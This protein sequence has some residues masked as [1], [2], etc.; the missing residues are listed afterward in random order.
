MLSNCWLICLEP[1]CGAESDK[2]I[3]KTWFFMKT[4]EIAIFRGDG[5]PSAILPDGINLG[6]AWL[7][8]G[9]IEI[10]PRSHSIST[11]RPPPAEWRAQAIL[12][13]GIKLGGRWLALEKIGIPPRAHWDALFHSISTPGLPPAQW[14]AQAIL[15]DGINLGGDVACKEFTAAYQF[16]SL[17]TEYEFRWFECTDGTVYQSEHSILPPEILRTF[18]R[19]RKFCEEID[20]I[21]LLHA[22]VGKVRMPFYLFPD[23]PDHNNPQLAH[24]FDAAISPAAEIL[25]TFDPAHPV[26]SNFNRHFRGKRAIERR[27]VAGDWMRTLNLV[28]TPELEAVLQPSLMILLGHQVLA[29]LREPECQERV[30]GVGSALLQT[31]AVQHELGKLLNLNGDILEDL[32]TGGVPAL[33]ARNHLV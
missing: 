21:D 3:N 13:D 16:R 11:P 18:R 31:L 23:H 27:R 28:P 4:A 20:E 15:P 32:I 24:I 9:N 1:E 14:R 2:S 26:I 7:A 8:P 29:H 33:K 6:G 17:S 30:L 10:P 19:G 12:P 25:A 22:Q 5:V